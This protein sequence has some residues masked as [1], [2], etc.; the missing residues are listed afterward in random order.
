MNSEL[1]ITIN[2]V[3]IKQ[4]SIYFH[5]PDFISYVLE[6]MPLANSIKDFLEQNLLSAF[7]GDHMENLMNIVGSKT[8][9]G[10]LI[11]SRF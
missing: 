5:H 8:L 1:F 9:S 7:V 3:A 4:C 10:K 11:D 6:V 2:R